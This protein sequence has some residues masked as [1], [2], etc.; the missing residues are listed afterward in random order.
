MK[1]FL[2]LFILKISK[3]WRILIVQWTPAYV[4][5]SRFNIYEHLPHLLYLRLY[6]WSWHF[7][8]CPGQVTSKYASMAYLLFW[9]KFTSETAGGEKN[10]ILGMDMYTLL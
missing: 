9:S 6:V 1:L 5:L 4:T 2:K 8:I 3:V 10:D 7:N